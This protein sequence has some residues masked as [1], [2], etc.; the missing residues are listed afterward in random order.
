[1]KKF[2]VTLYYHT[3][4]VVE[5]EA[6]DEDEALANAYLEVGKKK[7]DAQLLHNLTEDCDPDV[8]DLEEDD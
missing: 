2:E 7:Y 4:V 5:V 6:E 8:Y 3:D 1:M